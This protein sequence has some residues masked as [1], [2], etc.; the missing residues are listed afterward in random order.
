M[1]NVSCKADDSLLNLR[2]KNTNGIFFKTKT[3]PIR[4]KDPV[5][6]SLAVLKEKKSMMERI[7]ETSF[8]PE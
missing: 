1:I 5:W 8:Q 3:K 2:M 4:S 6:V 7:H